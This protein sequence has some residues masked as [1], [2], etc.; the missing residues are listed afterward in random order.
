LEASGKSVEFTGQRESNWRYDCH[1]SKTELVLSKNR[2]SE[3]M[4]LKALNYSSEGN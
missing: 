4:G 2:A 1:N 3:R